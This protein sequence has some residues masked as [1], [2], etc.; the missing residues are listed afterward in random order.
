MKSK[1]NFLNCL[2][3]IGRG[4]ASNTTGVRLHPVAEEWHE[5]NTRERREAWLT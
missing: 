1:L 3:G 4:D 2:L 5:H